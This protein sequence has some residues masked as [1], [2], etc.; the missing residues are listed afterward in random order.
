MTSSNPKVSVLV[1]TAGLS[2]V[3]GVGFGCALLRYSPDFM[4][5]GPG[6]SSHSAALLFITVAA[7]LIGGLIGYVRQRR[8]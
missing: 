1:L 2:V 7:P 4:E 8:G 5:R 3:A 6:S